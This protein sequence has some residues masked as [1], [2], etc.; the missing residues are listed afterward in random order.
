[1]VYYFLKFIFNY[2][3]HNIILVSGIQYSDSTFYLTK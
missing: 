1:M 3:C 2:S